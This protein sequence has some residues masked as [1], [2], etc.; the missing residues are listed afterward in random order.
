[1]RRDL[2]YTYG[3]LHIEYHTILTMPI[4]GIFFHK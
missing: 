2:L 1:M 3:V 4:G